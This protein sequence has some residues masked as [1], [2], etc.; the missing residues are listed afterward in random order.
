MLQVF[1]TQ[2]YEKNFGKSNS[3]FTQ[4]KEPIL[5][6]TRTLRQKFFNYINNFFL[7]LSV[8]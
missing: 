1:R 7:F 8:T 6:R 5:A 3:F 4:K 2:L